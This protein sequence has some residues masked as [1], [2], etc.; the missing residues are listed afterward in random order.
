LP[1]EIPSKI[2]SLSRE[3]IFFAVQLRKP[4][5]LWRREAL[6]ALVIAGGIFGALLFACFAGVSVPALL[7]RLRLDLRVASGPLTLALTDIGTIT[8][9][10]ALAAALLGR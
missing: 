10:F 1:R 6:P 9:Y 2:A 7:H 3:K 4:G 8:I 5:Y